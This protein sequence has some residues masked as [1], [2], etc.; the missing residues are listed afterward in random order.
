MLNAARKSNA[1][2]FHAR[3]FWHACVFHARAGKLA[4]ACSARA[5]G[6]RAVAAANE[7]LCSVFANVARVRLN[8]ASGAAAVRIPRDC[9]LHAC[10]RKLARAW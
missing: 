2:A 3:F 1:R 5:C 6:L 7:S 10:A 4:R 8:Q 9:I